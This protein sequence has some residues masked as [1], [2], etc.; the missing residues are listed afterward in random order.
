MKHQKITLLVMLAATLVFLATSPLIRGEADVAM[1]GIMLLV[2]CVG[3]SILWV[4]RGMKGI[5]LFEMFAGMHLIYYWMAF[6]RDYA[7]SGTDKHLT[8]LPIWVVCVFLAFGMAVYCFVVS[9]LLGRGDR[10]RWKWLEY[11]VTDTRSTRWA[12]VMMG[13]ALA[14][15]FCVQSGL[16][17]RVISWTIFR[18]IDILFSTFA[19]LGVFRLAIELGNPNATRLH[20]ISFL[21]A[22]SCLAALHAISGFLGA[23]G[24][25]VM[26]AGFGYMLSA[27]R[28]PILAFILCLSIGSFL[29]LGKKEW[30]HLH[31]NQDNSV[32]ITTYVH[33]LISFSWLA[34]NARLEGSTEEMTASLVERANLGEVL[35]RITVL[36]PQVIPYG[37]GESY[38]HGLTLVLQPQWLK[39]DRGNINAA[40]TEA[41]LT[42][43]FFTSIEASTGTNISLGPIAEAWMNG[44]WI[45][46][47]IVGSCYG[48]FYGIGCA[49]GW[50][51]A[52]DT[53]GFLSGVLFFYTLINAMELFAGS[54]LMAF[55]RSY[56]LALGTL[57]ILTFVQRVAK[58]RDALPGQPGAPGIAPM[59]A[60]QASLR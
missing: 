14:F 40:M 16:I 47:A 23:A 36:T 30:R 33:D 4:H 59:P 2:L 18:P 45:V 9:R 11:H 35:Q 12:W 50:G 15:Q 55:T 43:G 10:M 27:R 22:L 17:W 26:V 39:E 28:I 34:L 42:Y 24:T 7:T 20:R 37:G 60:P 58:R 29:N 54:M 25:L 31:W 44:G 3:P 48:L 46:V 41:S 21:M 6:G 57:L 49:M 19:M 8:S 52:F 51:R 13:A 38:A 5:P 56:P 32:A 53:L 1:G